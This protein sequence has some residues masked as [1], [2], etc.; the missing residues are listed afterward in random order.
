VRE[1]INH[2]FSFRRNQ[3]KP[4]GCQAWRTAAQSS[5]QGT[6]CVWIRSHSPCTLY[7]CSLQNTQKWSDTTQHTRWTTNAN[8]LI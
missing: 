3:L 4:H 6:Y 8:T 2:T 7:H 5:A 1:S